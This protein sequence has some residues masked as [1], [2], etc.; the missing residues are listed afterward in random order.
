MHACTPERCF[1]A[2]GGGDSVLVNVAAQQQ[3]CGPLGSNGV[4][5]EAMSRRKDARRLDA[6]FKHFQISLFSSFRCLT[7]E[8]LFDVASLL[9]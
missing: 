7:T 9:P 2:G 3:T 6:V 5:P 1:G 4:S 8:Q